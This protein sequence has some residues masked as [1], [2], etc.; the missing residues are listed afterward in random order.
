MAGTGEI[1]SN[2]DYNAIQ[3]KIEPV[4]FT[5]VST[6]GYGQNKFSSQVI[7]DSETGLKPQI[8]K[9]QWDNLRFDIINARVH[10]T[11]TIPTITEISTTDPIRYG[12]TAPNFQYNTLTDLAVASKFELGAGQFSTIVKDTKTRTPGWSTSLT[13]NLTVAFGTVDQA[14]FFFNSGGKVRLIA[15]RTGGSGVAQNTAWTN[16][17]D[18]AGSRDFGGNTAGVNFY[19][20]TGAYQTIFSSTAT[21]PYASNIYKIEAYCNVSNNSA[22]TANIVYFRITFTDGYQDPGTPAPGDLVDGTLLVSVTEIKASGVL[23][24]SGTFT[25]AS[26]IYSLTSISG[27]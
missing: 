23:F 24:P 25:V 18:A 27:S 17:L 7:P 14:R 4:M 12:A 13:C 2:E 6:S 20:L 15:N 16:L 19:S 9:A 11:G 8:T 5:G 3:R 10:Q 1:I 22:G 26:P 21:S